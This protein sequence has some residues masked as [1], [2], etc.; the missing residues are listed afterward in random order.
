MAI[1]K[2]VRVA[3]VIHSGMAA[4]WAMLV[5][6]SAGMLLVSLRHKFVLSETRRRCDRADRPP[7][8]LCDSKVRFPDLLN[9]VSPMNAGVGGWKRTLM[10][11]RR[12]ASLLS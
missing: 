1:L 8:A 10:K 6:V 3:L 4:V 9:F 2:I 12:T 11:G 5:G 7:H